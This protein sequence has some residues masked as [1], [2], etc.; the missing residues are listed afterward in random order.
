MRAWRT[1]ASGPCITANIQDTSHRILD[2]SKPS[3]G[4]STWYPLDRTG[5][6]PPHSPDEEVVLDIKAGHAPKADLAH[7]REAAQKLA[8]MV[9]VQKHGGCAAAPF[10]LDTFTSCDPCWCHLNNVQSEQEAVQMM[11]MG[12][13]TAALEIDSGCGGISRILGCRLPW[14]QDSWTDA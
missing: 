14:V 4:P 11:P 9:A 7:W 1:A 6:L 3:V 12:S 10:A 5:I 8:V 2:T 13:G